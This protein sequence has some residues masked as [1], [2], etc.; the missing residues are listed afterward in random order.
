MS[1]VYISER[2]S[3][4]TTRTSESSE[5]VLPSNYS[6]LL[7]TQISEKDKELRVTENKLTERN[8]KI[9]KLDKQIQDLNQALAN[10]VCYFGLNIFY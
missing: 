9:S 6:E 10:K 5:T 8:E 7:K 3:E 1:N 4:R 2:T